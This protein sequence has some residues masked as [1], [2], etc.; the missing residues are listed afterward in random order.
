MKTAGN[1][2]RICRNGA[3]DLIPI[4]KETFKYSYTER[5]DY[6]KIKNMLTD[7]IRINS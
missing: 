3:E 2:N 6:K 7:L 5:P 1:F 4:L